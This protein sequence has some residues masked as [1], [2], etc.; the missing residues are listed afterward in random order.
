MTD[1]LAGAAVQLVQL[2]LVPA[3]AP[4]VTGLVRLVRARLVGRRGPPLLQPYRDLLR[5]ARKDASLPAESSPLFRAAPWLIVAL[6]WAAT[7]LVPTFAADLPA[8]AGGD[9]IVLLGILA[10][11]RA[12]QALAALDTGTAVGGIGAGRGITIA[13]LAEPAML[14]VVFTVAL[15]AGSTV[16]PAVA[17]AMQTEPVGL[18]VSLGLALVVLVMV[19]LAVEGR[20]PVGGPATQAEPAMIHEA[21]TLEY[22]GRHLALVEGAAMLRLVLHLS[23]IAAI[24]V[25]WGIAL[26][27]AGIAAHAAGLVLYVAKLAVGGVLLALLETAV[28]RMRL[29]RV[30]DFLGGALLLGLLAVILLF[31][32]QS[33][34]GV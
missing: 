29:S 34:R 17:A 26:P 28:A 10:L 19:M 24:F 11:A 3:A 6:T 27:G 33:F 12:V 15:V 9:L 8:A 18:R 25:P 2:A 7:M 16:L 22:S 4:G 23:L 32:S 21:T 14:M 30:A 5:L 20:V 13:A 31:V 1:L